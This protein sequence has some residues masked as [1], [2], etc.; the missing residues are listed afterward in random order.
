M[1]HLQ[2]RQT[3]LFV[4]LA[5]TALSTPSHASDVRAD[6]DY[7]LFRDYAENRGKF[8][9]GARNIDIHD[10]N[11]NLLGQMHANAPMMDFSVINSDGGFATLVAPQYLLSAQHNVGYTQVQ[12]GT[13]DP[14]QD[15]DKYSYQLVDRNDYPTP[16]T[17]Q[18]PLNRDYHHPR[19]NKLVTETAPAVMSERGISG[20]AYNIYSGNF[21]AYT[22]AGSGTQRLRQTD[23]SNTPVAPAYQYL[24]GGAP[25]RPTG[26]RPDGWID[27]GGSLYDNSYAIM[28]NHGQAGDS[29]SA[30]FGYDKD[31]QAWRVLGTLLFTSA[32]ANTFASV[33]TDYFNEKVAEDNAGSINASGGLLQWQPNGNTS[34]ISENGNVLLNVNLADLS[35]RDATGKSNPALNHGKNVHFTG[36]GTL[37]LS[38]SIN[39]GAGALTFDGDYT[40]RSQNAND[41]WL[42]A[43]IIVNQGRTVNWQV[44]N[45]AGDRL[46]K[47]GQG[48]LH[49]NG[50][51]INSGSISVGDGTVILNQQ[52]DGA[53]DKQ[54]FST[55]QLV[56]GRGTV[57]LM[58]ADQ[59]NPD[60][61]R[62]GFRGG[63]LDVN[64]HDLTFNTIANV[65]EGAKIVN[66]NPLQVAHLTLGGSRRLTEDDLVIKQWNQAGGE[67][68][69]Y[70]RWGRT[71]Y[72]TLNPG[73]SAG[74]YFP[75]HGQSN[76]DWTFISH[77]R[78][79]AIRTIL[80]RKE[81]DRLA[82]GFN[83]TFGETEAGQT[84]GAMNI[85]YRPNFPNATFLMTGGMNLN[86]EFKVEDGTVIMAGRQTPRA[87]IVSQQRENIQD[88]DWISRDYSAQNIAVHGNGQLHI[89][90]NV[91]HLKS[92]IELHDN[93]YAQL[94]SVSPQST[95]ND[96]TQACLRSDRTG[97]VRCENTLSDLAYQSSPN[98]QITGNLK[99]D[100]Q[101]VATIGKATLSGNINGAADST[102]NLAKDSQW[103]MT[104]NSQTGHLKLEDNAAIILN[105][106]YDPAAPAYQTLTVQGDLSGSGHFH[107]RTD[108]DAQ[109]GDKVI[110][111]GTA[112]GSHT[113]HVQDNASTAQLF[114]QV[115]LVRLNPTASNSASFTMLN[116]ANGNNHVDL[117]AYRYELRE[118]PDNR[119][120][121]R[122]FNPTAPSQRISRYSNAALSELHAQSNILLHWGRQLNRELYARPQETFRVWTL[123]D[124]HSGDYG[125]HNLRGYRQNLNLQQIGI[126]KGI[127]TAN[128]IGEI[129][130]AI[131]HARADNRFADNI[132]GTSK[133][134]SGSL[135][136][137]Y[138]FNNGFF[139]A[140]DT[141]YGQARNR[142]SGSNTSQFQRNIASIGIHGGL[143]LP[144]AGIDIT[145]QIGS[146]LYRLSATN[147]TLDGASIHSSAHTV[148]SH[149]AGINLAKTFTLGSITLTPEYSF[150]YTDASHNPA[151]ADI[152]GHRFDQTYGHYS[153]HELQLHAQGTAWS[154]HGH[155]GLLRGNQNNRQHFGGVKLQYRW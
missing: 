50:S 73:K 74:S 125:S 25:L 10:N 86:G 64:G 119:G 109:Q 88:D 143:T 76:G 87:Y 41:T 67:L 138:R 144:I 104:A 7:Q 112:S 142:I 44:D 105:P 116:T 110:V 24:T 51:G 103:H 11:G 40:I 81:A 63:K 1:T 89:G 71:S 72:F 12:F 147:Y 117:G 14:H 4:L 107:H 114:D 121:Y 28:T 102:L 16:A 137:K 140:A 54:A 77:D 58:S 80:D 115:E 118:D 31:A 146:R 150:R 37:E 36:S 48:T 30:L 79:T 69:E 83:G 35:L 65:D 130:I 29:G 152:N 92:N 95:F 23:G 149:Q 134:V 108:I 111:Q 61:I 82:A 62:F 99:L 151:T 5:L 141:G 26:R 132:S 101:A 21:L 18:Y 34:T 120:S 128:G 84:N 43:G 47:L 136:G 124:T 9:V 66:H 75:D 27:V 45:P 20:A 70:I 6:I 106:H 100:E 13:P 55:V 131:S 42:G 154:L 38:G 129:G 90:R 8:T 96:K 94:G 123:A 32:T 33:R 68:Y 19:L 153:E 49:I 2:P 15:A 139:I 122:L 53:G 85:T 57:K 46:S 3:T 91:G 133:Q 135:H 145:P 59:V 126:A 56:S 17:P 148:A 78:A 113:L 60:N 22:R 93:A 39:Q 127:N 52:T 97:A 98:T 155:A